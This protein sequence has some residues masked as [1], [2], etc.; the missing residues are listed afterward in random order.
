VVT[1]TGSIQSISKNLPYDYQLSQLNAYHMS[2]MFD[3]VDMASM[4]AMTP[5][6]RRWHSKDFNAFDNV[7]NNIF[8][9]Y[10]AFRLPQ[11]DNSKASDSEAKAAQQESILDVPDEEQGGFR[12]KHLS[13]K[14]IEDSMIIFEPESVEH[15][16]TVFADSACKHCRQIMLDVPA[17]NS[18]GVRVRFLAYPLSGP[19]SAEGRKMANVWCTPDRRTAFT[20]S[21][22]ANRSCS[23]EPNTCA[24]RA[25][26]TW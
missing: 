9:T 26:V 20:R 6:P 13:G 2:M 11:I 19:Y 7:L 15:T 16:I 21:H 10:E 14:R 17:L 23:R 1:E 25:H 22:L 3:D 18:A 12:L 24:T 5:P 4:P 8:D